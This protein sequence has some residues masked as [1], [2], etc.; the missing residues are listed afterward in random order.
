MGLFNHDFKEGTGVYKNALNKK[1]LALFLDILKNRFSVIMY[2]GVI[3]V[4]LGLPVFAI[5]MFV[6]APQFTD[7]FFAANTSMQKLFANFLFGGMLYNF[8][9]AGPVSAAYSYVCKRVTRWEHVWIWSDLFNKIKENFKRGSIFMIADMVILFLIGYALRFYASSESTLYIVIYFLIIDFFVIYLMS[10]I[11]IY[12]IM[13]T[14]ECRVIDIVTNSLIF[15]GAN[16]P[17][18]LLLIIIAG[19]VYVLLVGCMGICG[20]VLCVIFGTILTRY[21]LEF[22]AARVLEKKS[23]K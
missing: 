4:L 1:G 20:V 15:A 10:H 8:C 22:Y 12:Q 16:L 7:A 14:Y 18:C 23:E 19:A 9:G 13:V 5:Y 2:A 3:S 21:P 6:I 17:M 11:F